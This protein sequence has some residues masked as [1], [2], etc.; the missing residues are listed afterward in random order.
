LG[1]LDTVNFMKFRRPFPDTSYGK[2][3]KGAV[4]IAL[5]V[6]RLTD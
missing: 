6:D 1:G 3:S 5:D 2:N 4:G